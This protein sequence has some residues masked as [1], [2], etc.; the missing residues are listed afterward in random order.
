M[1]KLTSVVLVLAGVSLAG[2]I[3]WPNADT[4]A[5][6]PGE[7]AAYERVRHDCGSSAHREAEAGTWN[8]TD[9][10][11]LSG[12][13]IGAAVGAA[14]GAALSAGLGGH[15]GTGAALGAAE[16]AVL[17]TVMAPPRVSGKMGPF[18]SAKWEHDAAASCLGR[19]GYRLID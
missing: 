15:V 6:T 8:F 4:S 17:G 16:G 3:H 12:T 10:V 1:V 14:S 13:G 11:L 19:A 18:E 9:D 2:C 5:M 7:K